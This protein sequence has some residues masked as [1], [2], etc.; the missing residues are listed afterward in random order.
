MH[1]RKPTRA[2]EVPASN[3]K[4]QIIRIKKERFPCS[5]DTKTALWRCDPA[6]SFYARLNQQTEERQQSSIDMPPDREKP[7]ARR[8]RCSPGV[9]FS[10]DG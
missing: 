7:I 9:T 8:Y 10:P 3:S 5:I 2:E 1:F 6:Y 4:R